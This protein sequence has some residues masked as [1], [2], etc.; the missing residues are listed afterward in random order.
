VKYNAPNVRT[1]VV[2]PS[3]IRTP[4]IAP[5]IAHPNFKDRVLEPEDVSAAVVEQVVSGRGGQLILP[6]EL[7]FL[8]SIRGWPTWLSTG[9]RNKL[10]DV[11]KGLVGMD[12]E[13]AKRADRDP[14][15]WANF[16]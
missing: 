3:W 8:T 16:K 5:L 11:A 15:R 2:N 7:G 14:V 6:P 9:L 1:T 13:A 10:S 4:L 12:V